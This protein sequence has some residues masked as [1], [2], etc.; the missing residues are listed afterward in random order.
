[1]KATF[2][3]LSSSDI[4]PIIGFLVVLALLLWILKG[5]NPGVRFLWWRATLPNFLPTALIMLSIGGK[6]PQLS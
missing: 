1:M 6:P 4:G 5:G 3:A 2:L